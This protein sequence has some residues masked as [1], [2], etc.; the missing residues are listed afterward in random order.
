MEGRQRPFSHYSTSFQEA[1]F[2]LWSMK[3]AQVSSFNKFLLRGLG[4]VTKVKL[5]FKAVQ[6]ERESR[7][8]HWGSVQKN[9]QAFNLVQY[10]NLFIGYDRKS[11]IVLISVK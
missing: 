6:E 10:S 1:I 4:Y 7:S 9:K 11:A 3:G 5:G 2:D 8:N